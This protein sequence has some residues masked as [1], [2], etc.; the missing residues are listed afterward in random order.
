MKEGGLDNSLA[1]LDESVVVL[2]SKDLF[3]TA[4]AEQPNTFKEGLTGIRLN[5]RSRQ[6]AYRSIYQ[7]LSSMDQP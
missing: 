1:L 2:Q 4:T 3:I 5:G 6:D 7:E